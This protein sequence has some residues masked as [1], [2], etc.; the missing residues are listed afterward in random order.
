VRQIAGVI[1]RRVVTW[2]Q[3]GDSVG[4]GERMGL[5]QFGSRCDLYLPLTWRVIVKLGDKVRGGETIVALRGETIPSA[6][7]A[8]T[9][10]PP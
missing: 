6:N 7:A 5:I 1:A 4:R 10:S 9:R 8:P 3:P 2:V